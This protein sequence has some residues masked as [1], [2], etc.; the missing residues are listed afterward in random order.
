MFTLQNQLKVENELEFNSFNCFNLDY[1]QNW[2]QILGI[3]LGITTL[4]LFRIRMSSY[5]SHTRILRINFDQKC[6][7][8][9]SLF[10]FLMFHR[11]K[12]TSN[13]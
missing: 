4:S 9:R 10:R 1:F 8:I 7:R 12:L 11:I 13:V 3:L 5:R 6:P 2:I